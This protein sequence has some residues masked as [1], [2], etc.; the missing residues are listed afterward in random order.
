MFGDLNIRI[1]HN[2]CLHFTASGWWIMNVWTLAVQQ[3]PIYDG[4]GVYKSEKQ[5]LLLDFHF[6]ILGKLWI[7][8]FFATINHTP[9]CIWR[10]FNLCYRHHYA[11]SIEEIN[12]QHFQEVII[13][14]LKSVEYIFFDSETNNNMLL[15][16]WLML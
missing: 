1:Y 11:Y 9:H 15:A 8:H 7:Q 14:V 10:F 12:I 5:T 3:A 4:G 13:I 6:R 2:V 16:K